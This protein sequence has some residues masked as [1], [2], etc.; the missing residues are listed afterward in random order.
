MAFYGHSREHRM[1]AQKSR[2]KTNKGMIKV[3]VTLINTIGA[4]TRIVY[5]TKKAYLDNLRRM[6]NGFT[7]YSKIQIVKE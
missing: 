4:K 5:M 7:N 2:H 3:R 1:N 6:N